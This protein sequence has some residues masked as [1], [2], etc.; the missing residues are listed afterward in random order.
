MVSASLHLARLGVSRGQG[1]TDEVYF[2]FRRWVAMGNACQ[3]KAACLT[4]LGELQDFSL[5]RLDFLIVVFGLRDDLVSRDL[6]LIQLS[7]RL[8]EL[9]LRQSRRDVWR[10]VRL[11]SG[12]GKVRRQRSLPAACAD[13]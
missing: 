11:D 12:G 13:A 10:H 7:E 5:Q 1:Q 3:V 9:T 2:L 6:G 4:N 8:L